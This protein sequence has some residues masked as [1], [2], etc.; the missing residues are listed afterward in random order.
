MLATAM[1]DEAVGNLLPANWPPPTF[2]RQR[3]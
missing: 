3:G 2:S 1:L